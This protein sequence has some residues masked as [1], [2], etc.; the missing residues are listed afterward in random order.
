MPYNTKMTLLVIPSMFDSGFQTLYMVGLGN[1]N[2]QQQN[3]NLQK[4][5]PL[6]DNFTLYPSRM[7]IGQPRNKLKIVFWF[8]MPCTLVETHYVHSRRRQ[9][10]PSDT[11]VPFQ[12][13]AWRYIPP[14]GNLLSQTVRT[15]NVIRNQYVSSESAWRKRR[16]RTQSA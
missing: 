2:T 12:W 13:T 16:N 9:H 7:C 6:R 4:D 10:V 11:S 14:N 8:S 3:M 5:A 1:F 15:S